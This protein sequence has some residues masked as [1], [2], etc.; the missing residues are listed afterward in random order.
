MPPSPQATCDDRLF[1]DRGDGTFE[2]V[3]EPARIKR[4]SGGYGNGVAVSDYDNDGH[5]DRFVTRWRSDAL[6][7]EVESRPKPKGGRPTSACVEIGRPPNSSKHVLTGP[8][9]ILVG[10]NEL[11][12][13]A[14]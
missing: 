9:S 12:A 3:S 1:R 8:I 2:N 13:G 7:R 5:P 11:A 14:G 6:V 10:A 4:L